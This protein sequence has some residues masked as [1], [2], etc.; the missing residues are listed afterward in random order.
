M[1]RFGRH[2]L[3]V[4]EDIQAGP[5]ERVH[6]ATPDCWC[7]PRQVREMRSGRVAW[8]HGPHAARVTRANWRSAW[9]AAS[10]AVLDKVPRLQP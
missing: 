10:L 9:S 7:G 3:H 1:S 6:L 5:D 2:E 4:E 8:W